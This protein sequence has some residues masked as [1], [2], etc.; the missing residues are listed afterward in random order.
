MAG[1][2]WVFGD[3]IDTDVIAPGVWLKFPVEEM[4]QHCMEALDPD[5]AKTVRPGDVLVAGKDFGLGSAREQS[6]LCLKTLG[7][8]AVLAKSF[9][10]IF[11]RNAFNMG[12]PVLFFPHVDEISA[13]D[14]I[15]AD[16][17]EGRVRN[18]T[19]GKD[20]DVQKVPPHLIAIINDGG[21]MP[22]LK[23]KLGA[24]KTG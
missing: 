14:Q 11:Y 4:A 17:I 9:S 12:L 21:L 8:S 18:L 19:T 16:W 20:Y 3:S 22:H 13:G 7:I 15:E 10:R 24:T 23:K 1:R 2:A 5:F 6:G